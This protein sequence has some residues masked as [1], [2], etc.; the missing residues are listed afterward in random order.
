MLSHWCPSLAFAIMQEVRETLGQAAHEEFLAKRCM[1]VLTKVD[2]ELESNSTKPAVQYNSDAAAKLKSSLLCKEHPKH[3]MKWVWVAVVN[4][5]SE[6]QQQNMTFDEA[7]RKENWFFDTLF[8]DDADLR[9]E[10]TRSQSHIHAQQA[11][12]DTSTRAP[13]S[14]ATSTTSELSWSGCTKS[15]LQII[16]GWRLRQCLLRSSSTVIT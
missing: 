13:Q 15:L 11:F 5:N 6:E 7:H 12:T 16:S 10:H 1:G 4:P 3:M 2:K 9:G 8:A 14:F